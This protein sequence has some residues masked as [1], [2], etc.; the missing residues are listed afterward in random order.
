MMK[1]SWV[2]KDFNL[3]PKLQYLTSKK[4]IAENA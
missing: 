3:K 2:H 4:D 1:I